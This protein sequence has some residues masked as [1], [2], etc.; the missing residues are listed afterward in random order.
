MSILKKK[1]GAGK[2][3]PLALV[4][5]GFRHLKC[6]LRSFKGQKW[7]AVN[8]EN[9]YDGTDALHCGEREIKNKKLI[10]QK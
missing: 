2:E 9:N 4:K 1:N 8:R 5:V 6:V 3:F 7:G 10:K